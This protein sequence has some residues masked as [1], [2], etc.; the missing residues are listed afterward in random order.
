MIALLAA[1]TVFG[2][3]PQLPPLPE[4][5]REPQVTYLDRSGAVLGV[6]GG[7]YAPPADL[8]KLP[9]YVPAAFVAVEDR[10]FYEHTGFDPVG[11]ARAIVSDLGQGRAAQ[12][13]STITQQLARNLFLSSDRTMERKAQELLYAVQL[14]RTYS[15]RQILSLYLSRIYFGAGA[16]GIE[17]ASQ[18]YFNKPAAR[19]TL[20]EAAMLA[21]IPK[22]PTNYNPA[23]EPERSDERAGI[24]LAAMVETGAITPAERA[25]AMAQKPKVWKSAPTASAQYFLDWV[26][27]QTRQLAGAP[28]Q[29]LVVETTLDLPTETAAA[30]A[31]RA[32]VA[33]HK[34]QA[35]EQAALVTVDGAG[36]VRA[37]VGGT[38]YA[39]SPFNRAVDAR[40]QAGSAWKPF[41]YLTALEAGRTPDTLVVDEPVT[42]AGWTP[43]NYEAGYLGEITLE[44]ALAHSINTVAARLADE[45]GRPTVAATARRVG[46]VS[47]INTDPAM[48]L[49]TTQ[50]SPLEMA[51]AYAVFSNGGNRVAAYGV[52]RIRT[53]G[54]AVLYQRKPVVWTPV[55]GNP[56]LSELNRMLRT[57]IASGTG[58]RAAIPRYDLAGKTGTTSDYKDAWFCGFTGGFAT[59]VWMGRDDATP[60]RKVTGAGAPVELWRNVMSAELK[61]LPVQPIPAGPAPP[62]PPLVVVDPATLPPPPPAP[63]EPAPPPT[64]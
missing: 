31:T 56:P 38:D 55:I 61:R 63:A 11:I 3:A 24:V 7:R 28:R 12:G 27:G 4:I 30:E 47:P 29:D 60:M 26:D 53:A 34:A 5:R 15:K 13:A 8:A 14:E 39:K 33:G 16:Y 57:V 21:A 9:T 52:E 10:R 32:S 18:R 50:V 36:R 20:K 25:K 41:V 19:L 54:G 48:A 40:R 23:D 44:Q 49:G 42:I 45:V 43:R 58:V 37:M 51:Q 22:S 59:V 2:A 6:R 62:P 35:I 17:A 1:A 64:N 46:I